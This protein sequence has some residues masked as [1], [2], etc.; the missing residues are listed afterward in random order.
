MAM[1]AVISLSAPASATSIDDQ[2]I[3][4]DYLG[5]QT[6]HSWDYS[7]PAPTE[8]TA[9]SWTH[10]YTGD[11]AKHDDE[12]DTVIHSISYESTYSGSFGGNIKD[13]IEIQLGISFSR[14]ET[15]G[16]NK[17]SGSLKK[18]EYIKAYWIKNYDV[19]R[20]KQIDYQ[21]TYGFA[22]QYPGGPYQKV[23]RYDSVISYVNVSKALEPKIKIEY[24]KDGKKVRSINANDM[25]ERIEYYEYVGGEYILV[26]TETL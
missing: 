17:T 7:C 8:Q 3:T 14:A 4:P 23:D 18:G 24:Y 9:G 25:P 6:T 26:Y 11:P 12:H 10:L 16:V 15:F 21:H 1:I 13:R 5:T 19:Y 22:Q 20:V 2:S